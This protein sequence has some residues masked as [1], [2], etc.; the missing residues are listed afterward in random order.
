[1][2]TAKE[3]EML[4]QA[5]TQAHRPSV[6]SRVAYQWKHEGDLI[7]HRSGS[8]KNQLTLDWLEA[9]AKRAG[10]NAAVLDVGCAYGNMLTMLNARMNKPAS[11]RLEGI[12]LHEPGM[13]YANAFARLVPGYQNCRYQV[14]DLTKGLPFADGSFDAIN[15]GDVLEHI[16]DPPAALREL[17]RLLRPG[18]G[19]LISTPIEDSLFKRLARLA[20]K[21]SG[22]RVYK[23]YYKGKDTEL[24]EKGQPKMNPS[25]GN[26]HVSEMPYKKLIAMLKDAGFVVEKE[27]SM[28]VLSGSKWFDRHPFMLCGLLFIEAVHDVLQFRSWGHSAMLLL[29]VK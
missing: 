6:E 3:L 17:R 15:L 26:D 8:R 11:V 22:G 13:A 5:D 24:D 23:K 28:T 27:K 14:A 21:L 29:R 20:N 4:L 9:E 19:L 16:D 12:D 1:M 2:P 7:G 18:G 10:P 25:V